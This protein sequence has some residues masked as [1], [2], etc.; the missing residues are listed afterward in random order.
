MPGSRLANGEEVAGGLAGWVLSLVSFDREEATKRR[1]RQEAGEIG[2]H[3]LFRR[4]CSLIA[5]ARTN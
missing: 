2:G 3:R 4:G 1:R 5:S